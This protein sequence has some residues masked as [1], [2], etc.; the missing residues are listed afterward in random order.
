MNIRKEIEKLLYWYIPAYF[1][2]AIT[3]FGFISYNKHLDDPAWIAAYI[4]VP[5]GILM[6]HLDNIV[7][8]VWLYTLAKQLNLKYKLWALFG[9]IAHVFA[10]VLFIVL[11]IYEETNSRKVSE[12][13]IINQDS[14]KS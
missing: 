13:D 4:I 14:L 6:K 8:A 12:V 1:L 2:S 10:A 7:I 3:A 5:L 9:L 11:Y